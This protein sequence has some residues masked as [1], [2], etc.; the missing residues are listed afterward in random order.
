M[1]FLIDSLYELYE[2]MENITNAISTYIKDPLDLFLHTALSSGFQT[3]CNK[4]NIVCNFLAYYADNMLK[5]E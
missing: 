4:T 3:A 1:A 2:R 5:K